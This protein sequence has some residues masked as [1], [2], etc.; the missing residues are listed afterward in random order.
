[1]V[2]SHNQLFY[3]FCGLRTRVQELRVRSVLHL[4]GCWEMQLER[5]DLGRRRL[6]WLNMQTVEP[7][8]KETF[9]K[10]PTAV[11]R[12]NVTAPPPTHPPQIPAEHIPSHS[13]PL[14]FTASSTIPALPP[15]APP[16]WPPTAVPNTSVQSAKCHIADTEIS[17]WQ[18]I[19]QTMVCE[20]CVCVYGMGMGRGGGVTIP[21]RSS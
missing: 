10:L 9:W 8:K 16:P 20:E 1:M 3:F 11:I 17:T 2:C 21:P 7:R 4:Q 6:V 13:L 15:P 5:R 14:R 12:V 19:C 18:L